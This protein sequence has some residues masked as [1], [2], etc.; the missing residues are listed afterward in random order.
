MS[1]HKIQI[2]DNLNESN[3]SS[4]IVL[5]KGLRTPHVEAWYKIADDNLSSAR[6]LL[7][8]NR[9][10]HAVFFIQQCVECIV[11][12]FFLEA[13]IIAEAKIKSINHNPSK[14][15]E[16]L[17][18]KI[19][20]EQGLQ[21]CRQI[22]EMFDKRSSFEEKVILGIFLANQFTTAFNEFQ[23]K[24]QSVINSLDTTNFEGSIE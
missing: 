8:N 11:K 22:P 24:I 7:E 15:F 18:E 14:A 10:N 23:L 9:V 16:K 2:N 12:G 4:D 3:I 21:Y 6:I 1:K 5:I 20:Y 17:Y 19:G 13:R